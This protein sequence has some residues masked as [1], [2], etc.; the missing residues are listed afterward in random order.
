MSRLRLNRLWVQFSLVIAGVVLVAAVALVAATYSLRPEEPAD[1][2][3]PAE[4]ATGE[5]ATVEPPNP[6]LGFVRFAT[7]SVLV[8]ITT[9]TALGI[10]AGIWMSRRMTAPLEGLAAGA[11]QI[12]GGDLAYRVTPR[13][14]EEM[15]G[16]AEAFNHMAGDLETA[17]SLRQHLLADVAHELRTP[18]TVLQGNLRAILDDVYPLDKEEIARLYDQTR[19]LH[20]LINDLHELAQ[21]EAGRLPLTLAPVDLAA[22]AADAVDA[23]A[24]I[25]D[26]QDV[27][28]VHAVAAGPVVIDGDRARL[29]QV[30][31]NLLANALRYTP[32]GGSVT[33]I[34]SRT[35]AS[36]AIVVCDTGEGIEPAHLPYVFDRFY[37]ADSARNRSQ[38]GAGLGLAI[39]RAL[40]E[41]HGGEVGV[42]SAGPGKGSTFTVTFP[43][44]ARAAA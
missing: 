2:P 19:H 15:I 9:G 10:G 26:E 31:Q 43:V 3:P 5:S 23:L 36:A 29:M 22:L 42:V 35:G 16:L 25:A 1:R 40:T 18:L 30:L 39:V 44:P 27:R 20:R 37:R 21:A 38:G 33:V 41:A 28:L 7:Q 6:F 12:G 11:A 8:L 4:V 13:G 34:A 32:A 14:T 17:E 24:P